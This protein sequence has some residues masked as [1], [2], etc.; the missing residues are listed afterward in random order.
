[1]CVAMFPV[2]EFMAP[3]EVS[4]VSPTSLKVEW[5]TIEGQGVIARGQVTEYW[6][7]LLTEQTNNPYAPPLVSQVICTRS[8]M[9][10]YIISTELSS[11]Q[12]L[13]EVESWKLYGL[14]VTVTS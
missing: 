6:V 13:I 4:A 11:L 14:M 9:R 12:P 1:M 8:H 7:N 2:P 3:P 5:S 10:L